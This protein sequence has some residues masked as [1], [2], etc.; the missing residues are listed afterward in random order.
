MPVSCGPLAK[1]NVVGMVCGEDG[2]GERRLPESEAARMEY[3]TVI[4]EV[5][6]APLS[7]INLV[8]RPGSGIFPQLS[9]DT[10]LVNPHSHVKDIDRFRYDV[11]AACLGT[12]AFVSKSRSRL[13][14]MPTLQYLYIT[15]IAPPD[16]G[17]GPAGDSVTPARLE[18]VVLSVI[19]IVNVKVLYREGWI[20]EKWSLLTGTINPTT[21][22]IVWSRVEV[23]EGEGLM[24]LA[25]EL[26]RLD[27][28]LLRYYVLDSSRDHGISDFHL[29]IANPE[30]LTTP[31]LGIQAKLMTYL[32]HLETFRVDRIEQANGM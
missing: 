1:C 17:V 28:S 4:P 2:L 20:D 25:C 12:G 22:R 30:L 9:L 6:I 18:V 8:A 27:R 10:F 19:V 16:C 14:C 21:R 11:S 7:R 5:T 23:T 13:I 29:D 24:F 26:Y 15:H 32:R 3:Q 31:D